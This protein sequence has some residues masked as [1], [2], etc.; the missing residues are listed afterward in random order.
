MFE[1]LMGNNEVELNRDNT[2]NPSYTNNLEQEDVWDTGAVWSTGQ[3]PG[4]IW[5]AD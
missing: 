3:I 5:T 2:S 4:Y 1:D